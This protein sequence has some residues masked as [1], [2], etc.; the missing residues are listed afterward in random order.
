M[1]CTSLLRGAGALLLLTPSIA[2]A[3]QDLAGYFGFDDPRIIVVDDG[4]GPALAADL[5]Q[6]GLTDL[7]V[8][9]DRKSRIEVYRQRRVARTEAEMER[10][11]KTNELPRSP[12]YDRVDISVGHAISGL[13]VH[14]VDNDG[15]LDIMY[16]GIPS[17]VVFMRQTAPMTFEAEQKRRV[18]G[19]S[20]GQDGFVIADV[21]GNAEPEL[22]CIVSGKIHIYDLTSTGITGEPTKLG[23]GGQLAAFFVED[24]N[25]DGMNDICAIVPDDDAPIRLWLQRWD[26]NGRAGAPSRKAG[27]LGAELRFEMPGLIEAEPVRFPELDAA[28]LAVIERASRRIVLYDFVTEAINPINFDKKATG[29]QRDATAEVIAFASED[30]ERSIVTADIDRDG[31]DDLI[32]TDADANAVVLYH[33]TKGA[34]FSAGEVFS[35]FKEPKAIGVGQWDGSGPLEVFVL[36]EEEKTVG[37]SRYDQSTGRLGF[38]QPVALATAGAEPV[39][40]SVV[41]GTGTDYLAVVVR[42]RRDHTLELHNQEGQVATVEL[43]GVN[44]PPQSMLAGEFDSEPGF[45]LLLFTPNE[46]LVMIVGGETPRVLKGESMPQFGLVQAAGPTNTAMLDVDGD[47]DQELLI[48]DENF[49]RAC[50]FDSTAGWRVVDQITLPDPSTRLTSL[51]TME[52]NGRQIIVASDQANR[53][54]VMMTKQDGAW[55]VAESLGLTG[56]NPSSITAGRFTG[57]DAMSVV[58]FAGDAFGLVRLSGERVALEDFATYRSDEDDRLEHEAEF[59]DINGDG[60]LDMIV[61]DAREQMCQIFTLSASRKL[62]FATEFRVFESRLFSRGDS[63]SF[64][65]SNAIIADMNGDGADDLVL[66]VHD[67]YIIYPQATGP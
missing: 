47:G 20:A 56:I 27:Q 49:V 6:D 26:S 54:L 66:E 3:Q 28:S 38:P 13:R 51:S 19:L 8:V 37:V 16:A 46:P 61:L 23:S 39:A 40:M 52:E 33:Q 22:C 7:L 53:R 55:G 14:D 32:V 18:R 35:A 58:A 34:G 44:R 31:L 10:S 12:Y 36:S 5:D 64:E 25:G 41:P 29:A 60:F 59:G 17:E 24:Y 15:L 65:P 2:L 43:E 57:D 48:A 11:G 21:Q 45:D 42:D 63:R 50:A 4:M 67:R 1:K 30:D 9:N 62:F